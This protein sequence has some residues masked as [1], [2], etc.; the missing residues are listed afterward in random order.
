MILEVVGG[1]RDVGLSEATSPSAG[2]G[3]QSDPITGVREVVLIKS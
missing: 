2:F 3:V 1:G